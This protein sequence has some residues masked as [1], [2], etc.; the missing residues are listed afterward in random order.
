LRE[1]ISKIR[2]KDEAIKEFAKEE[3]EVKKKGLELFTV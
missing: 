2:I 1:K 3:K